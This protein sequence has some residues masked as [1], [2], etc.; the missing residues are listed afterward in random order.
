MTSTT[1]AMLASA[2]TPANTWAASP[3][4]DGMSGETDSTPSMSASVA[5]RS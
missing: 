1:S 4:S 2:S 3:S 5:A